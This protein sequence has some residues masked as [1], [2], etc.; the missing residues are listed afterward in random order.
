MFNPFRELNAEEKILAYENFTYTD[1]REALRLIEDAWDEDRY[2]RDGTSFRRRMT[3][4]WV[5]RAAMT[6]FLNRTCFK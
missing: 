6:I 5:R 3:D 4:R 1:D 2:L